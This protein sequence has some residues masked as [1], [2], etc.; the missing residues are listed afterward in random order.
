MM[1]MPGEMIGAELLTRYRPASTAA[2]V[3]ASV[4]AAELYAP[5]HGCPQCSLGR[6]P[7][8][9]LHCVWRHPGHVPVVLSPLQ[10]CATP[11]TSS[12]IGPLDEPTR[13]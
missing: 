7:R 10:S 8:C 3:N 13:V 1:M 2:P 5:R 4:L 12:R 11:L 9:S 6:S